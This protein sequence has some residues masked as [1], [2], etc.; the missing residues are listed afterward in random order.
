MRKT[1]GG[2][3]CRFDAHLTRHLDTYASDQTGVY[4]V[5]DS[6]S[7]LASNFHIYWLLVK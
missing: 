1:E 5:S 6:D 7:D 4:D 3:N 2:A